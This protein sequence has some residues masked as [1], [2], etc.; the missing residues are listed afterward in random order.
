MPLDAICLGAVTNELNT[1]LTGCRIEKVYQ[2]DRD[3]IVI[4]TRG[5]GGARR[6]LVSIAAGTPRVHFI[7][8]ARENP[9]V[10]PMFCMLLRKHVQGAKIAAVTQPAVE[11]MLS[12]ELD[13]TDEMGVACKKHLI[14]EL[15]GKH[16][17]V[18]LCGED[19]RIIDAMRRVDGDLS[20][21]R[22]VLP[23]LFY[24]MPP[25]QDKH[26]PFAVSGVGLAAAAAQADGE[27][28]LDRFL[29]N[30]LLGFSPL[31]CRELAFR[32]TGDTAK[33]LGT[34]SDEERNRLAKVYDDFLAYIEE[35]RWKP[36]LLTKSEDS[37][38]FDFTF[39]PVTQYEGLMNVT[40][41]ESFS[42]L[43]AAFF[44]KKGRVE[45]MTRR[46]S[47][48][49]KAVVNARDRL[50]RKLS[51]QKKELAGAHDREKYKRTGELITANLYQLEKGMNKAKV[52]DYYN[53]DCPE[54]EISLDVRLTP[55]Q[56]AQKYFKLYT[57][58]KTA[59]EVL[60]EQ[61]RQGSI[62]LDYLESVLVQLSE[63]ETER[64]LAQ[65]REELTLSGVLSAKQTRNKKGRQKPVQAK[66]FYYRTTDGFDIFAGKNNLQN[67]LL[68]LKIAFKSDIWFHTQ[69]IHGSHVILVTDGRE[70][71]EQAMTEAAMIA[72]YHS[73]ARLSSM[74]PVDY[75]QVR[76]VKKPAGAKPGMVIY[77]VYQT[78]Y[79]T[80]DETVIEKLRIE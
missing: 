78:D 39:L 42:S 46:S 47:D 62:E 26:D 40:Q 30:T 49:H 29:L 67:D 70:P 56:N 54:V 5:Q 33:P 38:V 32:A 35:K 76:Q 2:P 34:L 11:R 20:G 24:R 21:K 28:T 65:L 43:L 25:A 53:K 64:D 36:F 57:K 63:A 73:K 1:V 69:K 22:Q 6:L 41:Y 7:E 48:L 61:I 52:I 15:M 3:E 74:V 77:H 50:A 75:T 10:P 12:I 4:Q 23:G 80:P 51:A 19:N 17:N 18:V 27:Q 71:T 37:A 79:V 55:Q 60:T 45:R 66:P 59:E 72:A 14:C 16:S 44:E 58:S 13:T 9:A 68:T 8:T 31:L